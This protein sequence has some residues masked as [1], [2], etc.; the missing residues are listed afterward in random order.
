MGPPG[1]S[2]LLLEEGRALG[3]LLTDQLFCQLTAY[4]AQTRTSL[5]AGLDSYINELTVLPPSSWDPTI[6]LDPPK[7]VQSVH[8]RL[9]NRAVLKERSTA[10]DE[11]DDDKE[12]LEML[13]V[14]RG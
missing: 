7:S 8:T 10:D 6:R 4:K 9:I 13:K 2:G 11:E 3:S 1:S 12:L 14:S 5:V